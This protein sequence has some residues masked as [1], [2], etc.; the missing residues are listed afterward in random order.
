VDIV[1]DD[2]RQRI[3][4]L[5]DRQAFALQ[6]GIAG[7]DCFELGQLLPPNSG[8]NAMRNAL[9]A[10]GYNFDDSEEVHIVSGDIS[11]EMSV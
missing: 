11:V 5:P 2:L 1:W 9:S 3:D 4:A 10:L 6:H 7:V 8:Q